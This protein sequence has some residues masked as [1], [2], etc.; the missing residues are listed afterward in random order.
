MENKTDNENIPYSGTSY[1][2][3]YIKNTIYAPVKN[4]ESTQSSEKN[5]FVYAGTDYT[6]TN[7]SSKC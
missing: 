7:N 1:V 5:I 2:N 3:L 6:F 4:L